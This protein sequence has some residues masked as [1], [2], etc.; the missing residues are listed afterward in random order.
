LD[1]R[2]VSES[3]VPQEAFMRTT[4]RRVALAA[5]FLLTAGMS[6]AEASALAPDGA[7]CSCPLCL[8][9]TSADTTIAP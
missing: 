6:F 8:G 4:V 7:G 5:L 3:P 9:R 1:E 2:H